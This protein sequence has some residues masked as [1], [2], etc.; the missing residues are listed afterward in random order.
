MNINHGLRTFSWGG[1]ED[2]RACRRENPEGKYVGLNDRFSMGGRHAF[3][4]H[5]ELL[6]VIGPPELSDGIEFK[7]ANYDVAKYA[8]ADMYTAEWM[9]SAHAL[10]SSFTPPA[11]SSLHHPCTLMSLKPHPARSLNITSKHALGCP[12]SPS[13]AL[14]LSGRQ[15]GSPTLALQAC[16]WTRKECK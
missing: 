9:L 2:Y 6:R 1:E 16:T 12:G 11:S 15:C 3:L 8:G 14:K 13:P 10:A 7:E 4:A 5:T